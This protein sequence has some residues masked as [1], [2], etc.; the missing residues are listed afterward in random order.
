MRITH[1]LIGVAFAAAIA[2]ACQNS[3]SPVAP[4]TTPGNTQPGD[5]AAGAMAGP[6]GGGTGGPTG[7]GS[8]GV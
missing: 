4:D 7:G 1:W 8:G 5:G 2:V 6:G 3:R